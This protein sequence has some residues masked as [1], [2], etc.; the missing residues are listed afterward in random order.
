[1]NKNKLI[2]NSIAYLEYTLEFIGEFK[3]TI[4]SSFNFHLH[5]T[6]ISWNSFTFLFKFDSMV[7]SCLS[8]MTKFKSSGKIL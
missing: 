3:F 8:N 2:V 5:S 6:Q 1:M 4:V 7:L